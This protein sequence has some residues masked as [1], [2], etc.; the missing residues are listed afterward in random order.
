MQNSSHVR[1][2]GLHKAHADSIKAAYP[3]LRGRLS[4]AP[5]SAAEDASASSQM[6]TARATPV[7]REKGTKKEPLAQS[8]RKATKKEPAV[9]KG[10]PLFLDLTKSW[11]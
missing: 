11:S 2:T 6:K 8:S 9:N 10:L 7:A 3:P 4:K 1:R 5:A